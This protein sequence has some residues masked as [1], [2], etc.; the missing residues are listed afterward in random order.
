MNII[1][2]KYIQNKKIVTINTGINFENEL[3]RLFEENQEIFNGRNNSKLNVVQRVELFE[4]FFE[5][6]LQV[7]D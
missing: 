4:Q 2:S 6:T 5:R 3:E 7:N 1:F